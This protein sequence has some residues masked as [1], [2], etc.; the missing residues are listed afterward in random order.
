MNDELKEQ[1]SAL[2]DDELSAEE[3]E[4]VIRRLPRSPGL[5]EQMG[6]YFLIRN[7][8][9]RELPLG[10]G[11]DLAGR[12]AAALE[13]EPAYAEP[14]QGAAP[15]PRRVRTLLRPVA[16]IGIAASVAL[17]AVMI[18]PRSG[19]DVLEVPDTRGLVAE[20]SSSTS[21]ELDSSPDA[22]EASDSARFVAETPEPQGWERL[23]PRVRQR[24]SGYLVNHSEYSSTGK[25]G[26][27]MTYVRIAG[28]EGN[29]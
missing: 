7:A 25:L 4:L 16:G 14:A 22:E 13:T 28:H 24:L 27:V 29:E 8:L 18:W 21:A 6:R 2:I 1:L 20:V 15:I 9:Q 19:S 26:G 10:N 11:N 12:V 17:V 3:I 23:D 5:L